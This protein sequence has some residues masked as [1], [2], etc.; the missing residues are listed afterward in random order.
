MSSAE[1]AIERYGVKKWQEFED[2]A[3][4]RFQELRAELQADLSL[5][6]MPSP[7]SG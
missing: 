5:Y 2:L 3:Q 6:T 7:S 4:A 1:I